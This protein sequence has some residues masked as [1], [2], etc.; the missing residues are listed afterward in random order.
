[1]TVPGDADVRPMLVRQLTWEAHDVVSLRLVPVDGAEVPGWAPGAHVDLV[2][3]S[4]AVRQYSLCGDPDDA[5]GYT[6]AVLREA[7]GR[8]GSVE[9]HDSAL[10]GRTVGVRGPRNHFPLRD[11]ESYL[12]I[13]G[14]IGITP[15]LA[16]AREL[17]RRGAKWRAVYG[18]RSRRSMAFVDQLRGL[19]DVAIVP[20]DERGLL[21]L[22]GELAA[23]G[24]GTAVYCCGP[25][26]LLRAVTEAAQARGLELRFE[27]FGADPSR[28]ADAAGAAFEVVLHRS[29]R[30]LPIPAERSILDAVRELIPDTPASCEEGFC[31]TCE[32][33]V[34]E[35]VPEHR[36]TILDDSERAANETMMICVG[37]SRTPRLVLDL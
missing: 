2:V 28:P 30:T 22:G 36:D 25:E 14:G 5:T 26:R 10:I 11:A 7:D 33:R 9:I 21:D 37:R 1:M 31:G 16:M 23:V 15:I 18:G 12:L 34:L 4:G 17:A 3:P 8:G 27:R 35:G 24:A 19:G 32:T 20:E 6:V 13:A 29:G